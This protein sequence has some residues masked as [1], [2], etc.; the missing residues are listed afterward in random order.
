MLPLQ[1]ELIHPEESSIVTL[2]MDKSDAN[3]LRAT[4]VTNSDKLTNHLHLLQ[5]SSELN[6][7]ILADPQALKKSPFPLTDVH[8]L[9]KWFSLDSLI[10]AGD[11]LSVCYVDEADRNLTVID[12]FSIEQSFTKQ[13]A[14]G[15]EPFLSKS[16]KAISWHLNGDVVVWEI[17]EKTAEVSEQHFE[18]VSDAKAIFEE[19]NCFVVAT[20]EGVHVVDTRSSKGSKIYTADMPFIA[21]NTQDP[22]KVA[23]ANENSVNIVDLRMDKKKET[24]FK[25]KGEI[26]DIC[27]EL[28][29]I[30]IATNE[31]ALLWNPEKS[32]TIMEYQSENPFVAI[33]C[34]NG[35]G[36]WSVVAS[37]HSVLFLHL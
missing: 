8:F 1:N 30:A 16:K 35:N 18:V 29:H 23:V 17:G 3:R 37:E 19:E 2:S 13:P 22:N 33:D 7:L 4:Y 25:T 28:P 31:G 20:N 5:Y 24:T 26:N 9:P 6:T 21:T 12:G 14:L 15:I 36:Q 11:G 10:C 34:A 27:W 32:N